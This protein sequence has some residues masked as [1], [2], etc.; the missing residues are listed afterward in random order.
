MNLYLFDDSDSAAT[1]GIGSYI[2]ELTSALKDTEISIYVVHIN[3]VCQKF[4]IVKTEQV[5]NWYIPEAH[6]NNHSYDVIQN[7]ENYYLN[8]VYLLRI[9]IKDTHDLVFH[10]NH[11][12]CQLLVRKLKTTFHCQIVTTVHYTK[13][14]LELYGN[15]F[16]FRELI[17]KSEKQMDSCEQMLFKTYEYER[18]LFNDVDRVIVL[19]QNICDILISEYHIERDKL[20]VIPNGLEDK[21][22]FVVDKEDLRKKWRISEK[23]LI[24]LFAGRFHP[25]KG[26]I[27]LIAA[28]RQLL[29]KFPYCRLMI[30]GNGYYDI[31]MQ[32]A[33][34]ICS[35]ITF[36]GL[37]EK[38]ELSELYQ[39]AD[40]GVVPSLFETFGYVAAEMMMYGLPVVVTA[41]SGLDEL[42]NESCGLKVPV[43]EFHDR[44]EID[45]NILSQRIS[46]LL[47][48][49]DEAK[50]LG[51]NA[52]QRYL[53]KYSSSVFQ[54]NMLD[55]YKTLY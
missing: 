9:H 44:V 17:T 20:F 47:Q 7:M 3:K 42:V 12:L 36:T 4:E 18:S 45:P 24:I 30:A 40:V 29:E 10:F 51:K 1:Y 2:R 19:T 16:R 27:F 8:L 38:K 49:P 52:R 6:Q 32:S 31:Y 25:V 35:K 34:D 33:K 14:A 46:Y 37:L 22:P 28:F 41:T 50:R 43:T 53:E 48:C 21:L 11:S 26:L 55:F 13:W 39:I 54:S 15:L 23:E 5:E